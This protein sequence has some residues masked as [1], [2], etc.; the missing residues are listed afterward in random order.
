MLQTTLQQNIRQ[1]Y[2]ASSGL[3]EAIWGEHM[4]HGYYGPDGHEAKDHLQAQ[5]DLVDE[6]LRWGNVKR[7]QRILDVGCGI[8]GSALYLAQRYDAEV[9]G[10]TLS[11]VQARRAEQRA[12]AARMSRRVRFY[13]ADAMDPPIDPGSF[14]LVWSL[15]SGEHM[16]Q[17]ARFLQVCADMLVP[18]GQFLM[19]TWCHRPLPPAL[20][21]AEQQ[22]LTELY[23]E[24]HL[25]YILSIPAYAALAQEAG[26]ERVQTADWSDAVSPFWTAVLRSALT[27]AGVLG[28]LQAGW[29]TIKG[30][31]A[32]RLMIQGYQSGVIRF[33]LVQGTKS[34][35]AL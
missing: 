6:L 20:T 35:E 22:L 4:H 19:A 24:Y 27:P 28:L 5:V 32:M 11:P 18:G 25:P 13:V 7:P 33:G 29:L 21:Y 12:A 31:L 16:P 23:R 34:E 8:G 26:L 10:L 9:I 1:F 2:D 15:E 17:K 3:W 14:D 30:A